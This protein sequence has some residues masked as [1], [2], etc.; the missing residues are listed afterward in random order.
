MT[1]NHQKK[2]QGA[3]KIVLVLVTVLV[4]GVFLYAFAQY[5][6]ESEPSAP[7]SSDVPEAESGEETESGGPA[8]SFL[9]EESEPSVSEPDVSGP[10]ESEPVGSEP[11]E[12][13]QSEPEPS[14]PESSEPEPEPEPEPQGF[15]IPRDILSY[16]S[17]SLIDLYG[18][19]PEPDDYYYGGEVYTPP[20]CPYELV[21]TTY[22][23]DAH[24]RPV[25]ILGE[26]SLLLPGQSSYTE[27]ELIERLGGIPID[28]Y[29]SEADGNYY[30]DA[31]LD[32][33]SISFFGYYNERFTY[34]DIRR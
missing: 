15:S 13:A 1:G 8:E 20:G 18:Y 19:E 10:D 27:Q 26:I 29:W 21:Y 4:L 14:A 3:N 24:D 25:D 30:G 9:P 12:P 6:S 5:R 31:Y 28:F 2:A 33:Y 7:E 34:F 23:E 17:K 11:S 16:F 32:G 22:A